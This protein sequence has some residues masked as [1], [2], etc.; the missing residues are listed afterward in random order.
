MSPAAI[1]L[2]SPSVMPAKL[3]RYRVSGAHAFGSMARLA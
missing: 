3:I 1:V 2:D